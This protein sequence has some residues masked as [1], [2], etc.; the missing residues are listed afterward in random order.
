MNSE[1]RRTPPTLLF[2]YDKMFSLHA[3]LEAH[4]T[5]E[6]DRDLMGANETR[7]VKRT[8]FNIE[9]LSCSASDAEK[10]LK[11]ESIKSVGSIDLHLR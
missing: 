6:T 4:R 3:G 9:T 1:A 2:F 10:Q 11:E 8:K 5:K 7:P